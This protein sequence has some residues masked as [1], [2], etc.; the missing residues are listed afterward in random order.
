MLLNTGKIP[1]E[2]PPE[3]H[4]TRTEARI[5]ERKYANLGMPKVKH[6]KK[7]HL[8]KRPLFKD[9]KCDTSIP[10]LMTK[11]TKCTRCKSDIDEQAS[12]CPIC[13]NWRK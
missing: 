6:I 5:A 11:R 13:A 12:Y 10:K 8:C 3:T 2:L 4:M 1:F 9:H 7:C